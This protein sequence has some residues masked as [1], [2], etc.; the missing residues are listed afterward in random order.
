MGVVVSVKLTALNTNVV[1][2]NP[3]RVTGCRSTSCSR[4]V[5]DYGEFDDIY[6]PLNPRMNGPNVDETVDGGKSKQG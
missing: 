4:L 6:K 2:S 1:D 5:I 3:T